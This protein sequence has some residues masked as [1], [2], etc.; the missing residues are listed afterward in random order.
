M[1]NVEIPDKGMIEHAERN[2][3]SEVERTWV[4]YYKTA[5]GAAGYHTGGGLYQL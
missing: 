2:D 4:S 5:A 3:N 1:V